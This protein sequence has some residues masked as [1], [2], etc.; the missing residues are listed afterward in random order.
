MS[1]F[2]IE[3]DTMGEMNVPADRLWGAQ[4]Q[5]SL[6]NF[7]TVTDFGGVDIGIH[8]ETQRS[9]DFV[10]NTRGSGAG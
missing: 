9:R 1:S 3:T 6:E 10:A 2:R 4:T 8:Q 7:L 5:R